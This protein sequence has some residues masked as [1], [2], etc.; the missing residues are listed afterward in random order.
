[1]RLYI[2]RHGEAEPHRDDDQSRA[3]T[4]AGRAAVRQLWQQLHAAG[5]QVDALYSS[6]YLR[7][8]QTA[9]E[10]S[11][12]SGQPLAAELDE[13]VPDGRPA[14]VLDW[15]LMQPQLDNVV[16]VS[17][18]PLVALLVGQLADGPGARVPMH[19]G[20]VASL[21][22]DVAAVGG[23]RLRWLRTPGEAANP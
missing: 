15:L 6:P 11:A 9:D 16:L 4:S 1:M 22:L 8:R 7:A 12:I 14:Q 21:E 5:I 19:V 13:L 10:I 20:S 18:M 2:V 23:G 17:H 3:L